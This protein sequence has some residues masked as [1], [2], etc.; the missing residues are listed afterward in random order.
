MDTIGEKQHSYLF[1]YPKIKKMQNVFIYKNPDTLQKE[2]QFALFFYI[3]KPRH[4]MLRYF[5]LKN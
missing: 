4:F 2:R 1:M 3:Q 5:H